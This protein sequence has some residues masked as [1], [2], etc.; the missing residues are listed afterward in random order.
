[1]T[2]HR[3]DAASVEMPGGGH[4]MLTPEEFAKLDLSE[5]VRLLMSGKVTFLREGKIISVPEALG[6]D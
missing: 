2:K 6:Q 3:F 1:M 4:N 5:R